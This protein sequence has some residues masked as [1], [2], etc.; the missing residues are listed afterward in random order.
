MMNIKLDLGPLLAVVIA[1]LHLGA[2]STVPTETTDKIASYAQKDLGYTSL[3]KMAETLATGKPDNESGF[4]LLDRGHNALAWRLFMADKAE[5]TIDA[6]YFLWKNDRVGRLFIQHLLDAA[7]RGVRVRL[8]VDDSMTDSDPLYLAKLGT[9]PNAE[10]RIYKPF[11]PKHKSY[12]FRWI[13]FAA[14]FK[15]LNRRMHNKLYIADD[16]MVITGGRNI[17]EDYFEYLAPDVFRSRDLMGVGTIA[18]EA[19]DSFDLFWNSAWAVPIAMVVDPLPTKDEAEAFRLILDKAD[20]DPANYP[21]GYSEVGSLE[22][23]QARLGDELM[24]GQGRLIYDTVPGENGEAEVPKDQNNTV[25]YVLHQAGNQA[26]Q[27]IIIES[28]YLILTDK[29]MSQIKSQKER[30]IKT[31]ALTNSLSSNNHTTAFVGY[32]K[33]RKQQIGIFSELYEYRSDASAQTKLYNELAP[34]QD[35][36]HFGIHAKTSVFDR[37]V[38]FIGSYNLD[39]RSENLNTE[40]G[41]L[42]TSEELG[43]AVANSILGDMSPGNSWQVR[44][45]GMGQTEW[46]TFE[47]G[48]ETIEPDREPLSSNA[49]KMEADLVEPFTPESEM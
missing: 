20:E 38:V 30:D 47:N 29:T 24:W 21:P 1:I 32:R 9:H 17:G 35:V 44:Q 45:N 3:G 2:C 7:E 37:S 14:D 42:V 26:T 49:R 11:G 12:V 25:G 27:E 18:N 8:L 6:Q 4:L 13:D 19:S 33:Q 22:Q 5:R 28:A 43:Q 31:L 23:A 40:N 15:R 34:G 48:V 41:F 46:V 39:P 36:P 10:V 16:S